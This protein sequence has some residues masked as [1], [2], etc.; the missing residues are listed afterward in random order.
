MEPPRELE[1]D[2]T[3]VWHLK[4]ALNSLKEAS[5]RFQ[6]PLF[7]ILAQRLHFAQS[8]ACPTL[9]YNKNSAVRIVVH[10]DDPLAT[11]KNREA[12]ILFENLG[13]WLT[14]RVPPAMNNTTSTIYLGC[15]Y[16]RQGDTFVEA[17][18]ENYIKGI[19]EAAGVEDQRPVVSPGVSESNKDDGESLAYVGAERHHTYRKVVG[20]A[21][22]IL[23]RRPDIMF[24]LKE[25]GRRLQEPREKDWRAMQRL[26][27]YLKGTANFALHP[28]VGEEKRYL[29]T[30]SDSDWAGCH[31]TRRS[32]SCALVVWGKCPIHAHS[33]IQGAVTALSSPEAEYYACVGAAAEALYAQQLIKD[34]GF[35][36]EICL[37]TDASSAK[38]VALRQ[39]LGKIRH[40]EVKYLWLQEKLMQKAL[41]N[42]KVKGTENAAD[43]GTKHV[44]TK[45]F[46]RCCEE[47]GLTSSSPLEA[48]RTWWLHCSPER[49]QCHSQTASRSCGS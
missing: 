7:E 21:Q 37:E 19:I 9:L 17:P 45:I 10:V 24:A 27:R 5:L 30:K 36:T 29:A 1:P 4:K 3:K 35:E 44:E 48:R 25:L 20:K 8:V 11:G 42:A 38:A 31:D 28:R 23:P 34:M 2:H 40:L 18:A 32:T 46:Q 22:F 15:R 43:L 12:D 14:V 47:L 26:A 49:W 13:K 41:S 39:G 16:W 6:Q 33:R